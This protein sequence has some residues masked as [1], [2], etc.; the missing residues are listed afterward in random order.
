MKRSLYI[1]NKMNLTLMPYAVD[2]KSGGFP[3]L[4]NYW[5]NFSLVNNLKALDIFFREFIGLLAVKIILR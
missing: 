1:A 4:S 3:F 5:Q 2:F